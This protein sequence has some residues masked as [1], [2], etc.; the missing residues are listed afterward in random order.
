MQNATSPCTAANTSRQTVAPTAFR[1]MTTP[2][3]TPVLSASSSL[4]M[5]QG[6][7][8]MRTATST[9]AASAAADASAPLP[10]SPSPVRTVSFCVMSVT[11]QPSRP[12]VLPAGRLSCLGPGSWSMEARRGMNTAFCAVAVSSRWA[13]A[14]SCLTRVPTTACLAMRTNLLLGVPAAARR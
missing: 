10:M 5:I 13:P 1:A 12:S 7:C 8:S 3:P 6:N 11:A 4:G 9:R 14:P 2:S